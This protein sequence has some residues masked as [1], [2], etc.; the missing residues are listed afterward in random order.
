MGRFLNYT[1]API[2]NT[3]LLLTVYNVLTGANAKDLGPTSVKYCPGPAP[4]L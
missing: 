3:Q 4:G 2:Q 1:A